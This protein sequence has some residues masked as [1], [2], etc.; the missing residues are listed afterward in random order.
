VTNVGND[1]SQLADVAKETTATLGT[2][3]LDVVADRNYFS[4]EHIFAC[5]EAGITV[6]LPKPM[7]T[8]SK[9]EGRFG[10]QDRYKRRRT[11][12]FVPPDM[13]EENGLV[14][15][16]CTTARNDESPMGEEHLLDVVQRRLDEDR[17]TALQRALT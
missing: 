5:E 6:A 12:T 13:T 10:K 4:S 17:R 15:R 8:N 2:T 1:R 3:N 7:T 14:L 16:R 9:A 11:F